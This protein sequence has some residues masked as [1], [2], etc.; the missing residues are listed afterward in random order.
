MLQDL[1]IPEMDGFEFIGELHHRRLSE[2]RI[3]RARGR[4]GGGPRQCPERQR[5]N[6][7]RRWNPL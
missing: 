3:D 5:L 4:D 6:A 2:A 1:M 7:R